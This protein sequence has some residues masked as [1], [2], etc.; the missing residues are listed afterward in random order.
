MRNIFFI[1]DI[2]NC[3]EQLKMGNKDVNEILTSESLYKICYLYVSNNRAIEYMSSGFKKKMFETSIATFSQFIHQPREQVL[4]E[5]VKYWDKWDMYAI[6]LIFLRIMYEL[7]FNIDTETET[8]T[9]TD[10]ETDT[11]TNTT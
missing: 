8:E 7:I 9:E 6:N 2:T 5:L 11:E 1:N 3:F 10:T 4:N